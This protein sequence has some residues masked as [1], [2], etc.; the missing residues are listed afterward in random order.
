[1]EILK[2]DELYYFIYKRNVLMRV[3][4]GTCG[5]CVFYFECRIGSLLGC[6]G[7]LK[8]VGIELT[9]DIMRRKIITPVTTSLFISSYL[10][11]NGRTIS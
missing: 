2:T 6:I 11:I 3:E 4:S 5:Y 7:F 1:M 9:E 10:R 8:S